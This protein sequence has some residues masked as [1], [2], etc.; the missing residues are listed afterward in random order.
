MTSLWQEYCFEERIETILREVEY[1]SR[2]DHHFGRPYL[3]A[4]QLAIEFALRHPESHTALGFQI[5]GTGI[6][7]QVSLAQYIARE[8]SR[9]IHS[10]EITD[11]EGA[12]FSNL[13]L[14]ELVFDSKGTRIHSSLTGTEFDLSLYRLHIT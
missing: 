12:F 4:Y 14:A 1:T 5:G 10:G 9:R 6:G 11:I 3:S 8:L 7:E 13:H 2:P